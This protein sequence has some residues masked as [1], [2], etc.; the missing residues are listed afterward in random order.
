MTAALA[1][2]ALL[3]AAAALMARP[4]R[5]AP[6][7]PVDISA[8]R[9][10]LAMAAGR[11]AQIATVVKVDG[12]LWSDRARQG[13][14]QFAALSGHDAWMVG[15][16]RSDA[17]E[18]AQLIDNLVAQGV[19]AICVTPITA[20]AAAAPLSRA[21]ARRIAVVVQEAPGLSD[22]DLALD[23]VDNVA[24]G[25]ALMD[26][27]AR[28]MDGRGK[29][30]ATVASLGT[31]SHNAWV[32]AALA[33]QKAAYPA[34]QPALD[35]IETFDDP[36]QDEAKLREALAADPDIGGILGTAM[37]SALDAGRLISERGLKGRVAFS[38]VGLVSAAG[39]YLRG[40]EIGHLQFWDPA[41]AAF[42]CCLAA[43]LLIAGRRGALVPGGDLGVPGFRALAGAA[44]SLRGD[45]M[46]TATPDTAAQ[47]DY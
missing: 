47:F 8:L 24:F 38:G 42:A 11:R 45:A 17:A 40:G 9:P 6:A 44:A 30:V 10:E 5:G 3:G 35:R 27:L 28:Q 23:A 33:R 43:G 31:R 12:V 7:G 18:Q 25:A 4:G 29:F 37:P 1:R 32:D 2:R 13:I 26:G 34:M 46:Q 14:R 19:D 41:I 39:G 36:G 16:P 21:R 15:P 22:A 20:E